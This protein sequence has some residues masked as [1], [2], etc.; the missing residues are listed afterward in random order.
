MANNNK[1]H[2]YFRNPQEGLVKYKPRIGG[3]NGNDEENQ[4]KEPDYAYMAEVFVE[5]RR[6]FDIDIKKRHSNRTIKLPVHFDLIELEFFAAFDQPKYEAYYLEKFGLALLHLSDFNKRALF[7]IESQERYR[8]FDSQ[9]VAFIDSKLK[10]VSSRFDK[11]ITFIK[12]FRLFST[13]DMLSSVDDSYQNIHF[14]FIGKGLVEKRLIDPQKEAFKKYLET[15]NVD[16]KIY[17]NN[18]EIFDTSF[19]TVLDIVNNFDFI[20]ATCS[21]SGAVILPSRYSLPSREFGFEI[22]NANEDLPIIGIVDTGISNQTPLASILIGNNGE[23]DTTGTGSF[24]DE[25]DHGTGVAAFAAFGNKLIPNYKGKVLADAKLLPIKILNGKRGAI[26]QSATIDLIRKA[27]EEYN[28]RIFT[29]TIG[30]ADF[31]LKDNQE[32][33]SYA[34]L[35]DKVSSELDILIFISTTNHIFQIQGYGD[36][37]ARFLSQNANIAPP[38][39]S[40]NNITIGATADNFEDN[41]LHNFALSKTFPAIYSRKLHYNFD[42]K[43]TFNS[44]TANHYFRK[45]DILAPGGDYTEVQMLGKIDYDNGSE[46]GLEV[47]SSDLRQRTYKQIGTSYA[48]PIA[49]NIAAKLVSKYP[50]LDMQTIKAIMINGSSEI[51]TGSEFQTF[52]NN[53][54]KRIMGYGI[55][56]IDTILFSDDNK[57]TL[58]IEDEIYPGYIKSFPIFLPEYLNTATRRIGLLKITATLCF[59]FPPKRDNQLLYC[60]YHVSFAIGKNLELD[61]N[62]IETRISENG[63]ERAIDVPDGYNGNSS[64]EIKLNSSSKG[65]VQDYYYK[66]KLVS[67][68]Q[69]ISFNVKKEDII[70]EQ[71][72]FKVAINSAFNKLLSEAEKEP[73]QRAIPYSLVVTIKQV[74]AKNETLNSLYDGLQLI[75]NLVA[76]TEAELEAEI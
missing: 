61:E 9:I 68:V 6:Q 53:E 13:N 23:F 70:N 58:I 63:N 33:S 47:L 41:E 22:I 32:F 14:S 36:Y 49:A 66:S 12:S 67:N 38:A 42:D 50:K 2:L 5:S 46:A 8:F 54:K 60:P 75:N 15:N 48:T 25:S 19:E 3:G 37:P 27:H 40:M 35:L 71:N 39:E 76:I 26:S 31:P 44:Q 43:K 30:Y 20:Y 34:K 51:D 10:N 62:H 16:H 55:P 65:W 56:D 4:K 52:S 24:M 45:P 29:L 74:P 11:K 59:K 7:A 69:K 28:V 18:A 64:K 17:E 73:F 57:A 72:C 21:G 1:S